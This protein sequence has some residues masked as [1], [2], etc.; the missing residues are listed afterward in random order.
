MRFSR[1]LFDN[2]EGRNFLGDNKPNGRVTVDPY[3]R[4]TTTDPV[5]GNSF[6]GPFRYYTT[7]DAGSV[8]PNV[9]E[10]EVPSIKS[11]SWN[12]ST[13]QDL[14]SCTITLYNTWHD[15]NAEEAELAGQLGKK[16]YFWPKR[17]QGD[18]GLTWNQTAGKGAYKKDGTWDPNFSWENVLVEDV[19]LRTYEGYGGNPTSGN[20]I[21]I[22][23]NLDN[24][25]VFIT[26]VWIVNQV[27]AGSDGMM[28]L[29]CTDIGRILLDQIVFPPAIPPAVYP[30][31]YYPPGKS[32][33]DSPWGPKLK[34]TELVNTAGEVVSTS[35][36]DRGEVW[37]RDF[38]SSADG[39]S[40]VNTL[41]PA[42]A[43]IDGDWDTYTLSEAYDTLDG[44]RPYWE[45]LPGS[46]P[47]MGSG[48]NSIKLKTWAGGYTVYVSIAEDPDPDNPSSAS[49]WK[50]N[51]S[52]PDGGIP[53]VKKV[54]IPLYLPDGMESPMN[55]D[56][57][58]VEDPDDPFSRSYQNTYYA[59]KVR[60][61]FENLYFSHVPD[62]SARY[63][64]GI[65]D[66]VFFRDGA[67]FN[68]YTPQD[69]LTPWT[70]AIEQH[71]TRGY[72]VVDTVGRVHGFGDASDF[73][74]NRFGDVPINGYGVNNRAVGI[75]AHP[76][77]EGYW[78]VDWMGH[79]WA[80][81]AAT[82]YGDFAIPDPY[83]TFGQDAKAQVR[84]IAATHTG[85]GYWVVYSNGI[86]RGFG[87]ATPS[88]VT[89]PQTDV[90]T[91][92]NAFLDANYTAG[93][94]VPYNIG[95]K[96]TAIASHPKK[97]GFWV[98]DGSGQV[99]AFGEAEYKG[100]LKNRVY[101][102]GMAG[103]FKLQ[104]LEWATAL[105]CTS[106]GEGYWIAFGSGRVAGF[107]SAKKLGKNPYVFDALQAE[108]PENVIVFEDDLFDDTF[109][110]R[111][112]WG[113]ARDPSGEGF[114]VLKANGEVV[115]YDAE[116]WG[117]PG[118]TGLTGYKWHDGNFD[119]DWKN[120]VKEIL[121]WGGF[122]AYDPDIASDE[123]P[124]VYG[125]LEST[126]IITD[127]DVSGDK[128]DK[129]TLLDVIKELTEVVGYRF[130]IDAEGR[131][132]YT[133]PNWWK[134]GNFDQ[135]GLP[136][137]I[138]PETGDRVDPETEGA[139]A[140]IPV[141]HEDADLTNY[142]STLSSTD[143]RSEIIIGTDL[144][145]PKDPTRT[146][147]VVHQPPHTLETVAGGVPTMRGIERTAIWI[148]QL[149]E[150][151]EERKLM[152]E[153]IGLHAWFSSR[154]GSATIVG[155]PCLS[156]D[157]QVRIVE[158][159]TS[160]SF[161]HL[162]GGVDSNMDLDS[163][164]YTMN[165]T[166]HWLGKADDW[167]IANEV[168]DSEY[169]YTVISDNLNSWQ[170]KTN[171]G[172]GS[173]AGQQDSPII[174]ATGKFS[175]SVS[176]VSSIGT[177]VV[178]G[179]S[180]SYLDST[181]N[182]LTGDR[183]PNLLEDAGSV[184]TVLNGAMSGYTTQ[185]LID[186]PIVE[187]QESDA[188][189]IFIGANDQN[190]SLSGVTL[191][192]F[193]ANLT[194]LLDLYPATQQ[195]IVFPWPWTGYPE[196]EPDPAPTAEEYNSYAD[197]AAAVAASKGAKFL[198]MGQV[199]EVLMAAAQQDNFDD[200][201]VD[202]IH[203]SAL[204]HELLAEQ[205]SSRLY[206]QYGEDT[207]W[208]FNGTL[209]TVGVIDNMKIK[210]DVLSNLGTSIYIDIYNGLNDLIFSHE[211][212]SPGQVINVGS[213]G[214]PTVENFTYQVRGTP[215]NKGMG[216]LRM[217]FSGQAASISYVD[218][219]TLF[220][221]LS[222]PEEPTTIPEPG[223]PDYEIVEGTTL[224]GWCA[225]SES[226]LENRVA[227]LGYVT[228]E[229]WRMF[230][231]D[232]PS[233]TTAAVGSPIWGNDIPVNVSFKPDIR[234][235][236]SVWSPRLES[237]LRK[238]RIDGRVT[239]V[240][241]W[242]EPE[243]DLDEAWMASTT[244][245]RR[246][247]NEVTRICRKLTAEGVGRFYSTPIMMDWTINPA[248][249]RDIGDW[250]DGTDYDVIGFDIYPLAGSVISAIEPPPFSS[251]DVKESIDRCEQWAIDNN[252]PWCIPEMG[253][254]RYDAEMASA[255][256]PSYT[257]T[258]RAEFIVDFCNYIS[259]LSKPPIYMSYFNYGDNTIDDEPE[260]TAYNDVITGG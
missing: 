219:T 246:A 110:R 47:A 213:L 170:I 91:F 169:I 157:D 145:D 2:V 40:T 150:N 172:L 78:V 87:D 167:V 67:E 126:G 257:A 221:D 27:T 94:Y 35:S 12:R 14:A 39:D 212:I 173:G 254:G 21:S 148:S 105:E 63:R 65:R 3:W 68:N 149:F 55:I 175:N 62:G 128:F 209:K 256:V 30:L 76:S 96:A 52:I 227:N 206:I 235:S 204:G 155:N 222:E 112:L 82:H 171:R 245:F 253:T 8:T 224:F 181:L 186:D 201:I 165:L 122:L 84:G 20:Y 248:S 113:L 211:L 243:N 54:T 90:A 233:V 191:P 22:D 130:Y 5:Y 61:T 127:T 133:S 234:G 70:F 228:P 242:H 232:I 244:N 229:V 111:I 202:E 216:R 95:L 217:S 64:A 185:D 101:N 136:V 238:G 195:L 85:N 129:K 215:L 226:H 36:A 198:H 218:D 164:D 7:Y 251:M 49:V 151:E 106:D 44:G 11:I 57:A 48:I 180:L 83:T 230:Y 231:G 56:L 125:N 135:N 33:F 196:A 141:V 132:V 71:P 15:L 92:M 146:G 43:A 176:E 189:V 98:T 210:I 9:D 88:Y 32:P 60:L 200:Y 255:G 154:T 168:K 46:D 118:Y 131:A 237:F 116:F 81:G 159:N 23:D 194:D 100:Q 34:N 158:R 177:M 99:W 24:E 223:D 138:D 140:F 249:G 260:Q 163:G 162:V 193:E 89:I 143:K 220:L 259:A 74:W 239:Y 73:D 25:N 123:A 199:V 144:P 183:W 124:A 104:N 26:G 160:E 156:I 50:G 77:G 108:Y 203:A 187:P 205:I 236:V 45:F 182:G 197:A 121:M 178:L 139:E 161:I 120:I 107:G 153:L 258:Y 134:A 80:Y 179:D 142:T 29:E 6:K 114:W 166:T 93:K 97:M 31:E 109:F 247:L 174:T 16:G 59:H 4:L 207:N 137:Y 225:T 240:T 28:T 192:E 208:L 42:D 102:K 119:G 241:V 184:G 58:D 53:Y 152:A 69:G 252:K 250:L 13:S 51:Q 19:I 115:P 188:L 190:T 66:L 10:Y 75:A 79:V 38:N 1:S 117:Q 18:S 37:I 147:Y 103:Q 86:V 72:W 41:Y 214:G 17:G